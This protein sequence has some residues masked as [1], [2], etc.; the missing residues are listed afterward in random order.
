M[1]GN[2]FSGTSG[3]LLPY[4]NKNFY[5]KELQDK[6]RLSVYSLLFNS[7]EVNS[8]FYKMPRLETVER[9]S[10]ETGPDFRFTFKLWKGI[11]HQKDLMFDTDDV[12][13]FLGVIQGAANKKGCLLVQ[14][15]PSAKFPSITNLDR[16]LGVI[17]SDERSVGW[18]VCVEFR[19]D[20]WYREE[21]EELLQSYNVHRVLHD[22][23]GKGLSISRNGTGIVY[24]RFHGPN[25]DYRESYED[26]LLYEY[27][28]YINDCLA[29]G[30]TVYTYFNNTIG[31]AI[32][33]LR[34]LEGY[35]MRE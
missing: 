12:R 31:A 15:P 9:W 10:D 27:S 32:A 8:S 33:N 28:S 16:L 25:G 17:A 13:K 3:I 23:D 1:K 4:K 6:S 26:T 24:I 11:T 29:E 22:K 19:D 2:Y 21:T 5:P 20:S 35:I 18:Q 30:K 14:L 34:T 7:L